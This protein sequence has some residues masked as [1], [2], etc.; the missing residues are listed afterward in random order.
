MTMSRSSAVMVFAE[1]VG[2]VVVVRIVVVGAV[3]VMGTG[4][5]ALI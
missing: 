5:I 2:V 1:D 3:T 4:R